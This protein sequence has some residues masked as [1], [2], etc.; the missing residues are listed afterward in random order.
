[1]NCNTS[2]L[3]VYSGTCEISCYIS[4]QVLCMVVWFERFNYVCSA[5]NIHYCHPNPVPVL[6]D[7]MDWEQCRDHR[8]IVQSKPSNCWQGQDSDETQK[9]VRSTWTMLLFPIF[10]NFVV[11]IIAS[12]SKLVTRT[13]KSIARFCRPAAYCHRLLIA[14]SWFHCIIITVLRCLAKS[15][16][17]TVTSTVS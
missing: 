14:S 8:I 17:N 16:N 6:A 2:P 1:M 4:C 7:G 10:Q 13:H 15:S 12:N 11:I 9:L 3:F 5:I